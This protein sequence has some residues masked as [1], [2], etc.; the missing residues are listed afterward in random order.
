MNQI[1]EGQGMGQECP[2]RKLLYSLLA[3]VWLMGAYLF[4][5]VVDGGAFRSV[6]ESSQRKAIQNNFRQLLSAVDQYFWEQ[7][8]TEVQ[9]M[10]LLGEGKYIRSIDSVAGESYDELVI[11][12]GVE[13]TVED[14][15]GNIHA[16]L[17]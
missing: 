17:N 11:R 4:L 12:L 14:G 16:F 10:E 1:P 6:A 3:I 15:S 2:S 8:V 13:F 5:Y 7:A 9:D